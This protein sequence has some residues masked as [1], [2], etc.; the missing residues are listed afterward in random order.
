MTDFAAGVLP[1]PAGYW[2]IFALISA[3][4]SKS[5]SE[6]ESESA[7]PVTGF[8]HWHGTA[9]SWMRRNI[10]PAVAGSLADVYND[11]PQALAR[12]DSDVRTTADVRT[13]PLAT[14]QAGQAPSTLLAFFDSESRM[15]RIANAGAGRAFLAVCRELTTSS[16]GGAQCSVNSDTHSDARAMDVE[17]LIDG[18]GSGTSSSRGELDAASV[19]VESVEV[20]DGDFLAVQAVS[21]WMREQ[22]VASTQEQQ[23]IRRAGSWWPHWQDRFLDFPSRNNHSLGFGFDWVHTMV[24]D[25]IRDVDKMFAGARGN[26]ASRIL[27]LE[28]KHSRDGDSGMTKS[29]N[30]GS[31]MVVVFTDKQSDALKQRRP[32]LD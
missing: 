11:N 16:S 2:S 8:A 15:L 29:R 21:G 1:V 31:V 23:P 7:R 4:N 17:E 9:L 28:H 24:P 6:S 10:V 12:L 19:N 32:N 3:G 27:Q 25:L 18:T 20:R 30:D 26:A 14:R 22:Q 5:E 13:V